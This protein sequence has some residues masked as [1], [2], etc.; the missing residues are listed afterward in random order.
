MRLWYSKPAV[1]G[2]SAKIRDVL[3]DMKTNF[4]SSL[5]RLSTILILEVLECFGMLLGLVHEGKH[6]S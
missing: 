2:E 3:R 5:S 6:N 1:G 4:L